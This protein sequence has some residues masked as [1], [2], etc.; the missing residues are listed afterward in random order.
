VQN[1]PGKDGEGAGGEGGRD[2]ANLHFT[3]I[4]NDSDL[5]D[6]KYFSPWDPTSKQQKWKLNLSQ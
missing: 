6:F 4:Y 2:V 5:G 1:S 3:F